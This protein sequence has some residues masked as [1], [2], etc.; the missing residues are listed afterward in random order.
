[1]LRIQFINGWRPYAGVV[2]FCLFSI[3]FAP[4][5]FGVTIFNLAMEVKRSHQPQE[6]QRAA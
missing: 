5:F 3:W 6:A 1:M 4:D 2:S